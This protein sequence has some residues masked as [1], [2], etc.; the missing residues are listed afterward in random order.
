MGMDVIGKRPTSKAGEYFRRNVW[1]WHPLAD[2]IVT[3]A[4]DTASSCK[5]WHTNEG[6]GLNAKQSVVPYAQRYLIQTHESPSCSLAKVARAWINAAQTE[7]AYWDKWQCRAL[8]TDLDPLNQADWMQ[9]TE[10]L[11]AALMQLSIALQLAGRDEPQQ[12]AIYHSL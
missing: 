8:Q 7:G 11:K 2:Y 4:P 9:D 10:R 3:I 1:H 5:R 6:D 12:Q